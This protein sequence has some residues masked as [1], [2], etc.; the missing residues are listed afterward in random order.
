MMTSLEEMHFYTKMLTGMIL[1]LNIGLLVSIRMALKYAKHSSTVD[2]S[3]NGAKLWKS[4]RRGLIVLII[5]VVAMNAAAVFAN[6]RMVTATQD[7]A[8]ELPLSDTK[9][10]FMAP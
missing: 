5:M 1:L 4:A 9:V 8:A 2:R 7:L 10:A 3:E 6:Y